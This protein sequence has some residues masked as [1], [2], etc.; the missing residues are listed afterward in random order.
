LGDLTVPQSAIFL[1]A[2]I[3]RPDRPA[4]YFDTADPIAIAAATKA[5]VTVTLGRRVLV[6]GGHPSITPMIWAAAE[7]LQQDYGA[8]V[9]LFQSRL[10]HDDFPAENAHFRN[11]T[12][13]DPLDDDQDKSIDKMRR[14]ML[15]TRRFRFMAGIFIGGM[16]GVE[17]EFELFCRRHKGMPAWPIASTGGAALL[18]F[19]NNPGLPHSLATSLDY[20]GLFHQLL[21]IAPREPRRPAP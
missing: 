5:L 11:V 7:D 10:F 18:L 13:V 17:K 14:R 20:I 12:Y 2:S 3:P 4:R 16:D 21:Q 15:T 19:Q 8:W 6:W 1:S 9:H